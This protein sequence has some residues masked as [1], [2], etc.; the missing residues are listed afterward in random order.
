MDIHNIGQHGKHDQLGVEQEHAHGHDQ[1][2]HEHEQ[3]ELDHQH[4]DGSAAIINVLAHLNPPLIHDAQVDD[5]GQIDQIQDIV[6]VHDGHGHGHGHGPVDPTSHHGLD[7]N[8]NL[9][10][11]SMD[12]WS[13][14][15][16]KDE[17]VRL[18]SMLRSYG[19][20]EDLHPPTPSQSRMR[21][22][23]KRERN[24][25][26]HSGDGHGHV[27]GGVGDGNGEDVRD[28]QQDGAEGK[29][30][31][32]TIIRDEE[33][34]KR[35]HKGRRTELAKALRLKVCTCSHSHSSLDHPSPSPSFIYR[36]QCTIIPS[37]HPSFST[38]N[39]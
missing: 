31:E 35:V 6:H 20:V 28:G 15:A 30:K 38:E 8:L 23:R 26:G 21:K 37:A 11:R 7:L 3:D 13:V 33:T 27:H 34:G 9:E 22:K 5:M 4:D 10:R 17:V 16:L 12:G 2:E 18:R 24:A 14:N 39:S 32:R 25:V 19:T 36:H 1:E 29:K